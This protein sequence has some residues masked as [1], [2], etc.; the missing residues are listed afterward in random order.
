MINK[1][2]PIQFD[3]T[4][5]VAEQIPSKYEPEFD[6]ATR[7]RID[8]EGIFGLGETFE[9]GLWSTDRLDE[10]LAEV[11]ASEAPRISTFAWSRMILAVLDKR[12][13]N[14]QA[15]RGA[16][17]IGEKHYDIG[18]DLFRS[19]LD[20]SMSYTS[21]YWA[22]ADTLEQAQV[23]KLDLICRKLD[24]KPGQHI[25]DI[26]CGWG[27]FA[28]HAAKHYGARV[29]GVTVSKEQAEFARKRCEEL[30]VDIRLQDYREL[31][32]CF[33]HVVSIEMIEAV[34]RKNLPAYYRVVDRCLQDGG[35]FV[36]QV[37]SGNTLTRNSDRRL[38]QF[39][40]WLV[41]YI[42]PDGYLP[43][44]DELLPPRDT[45]L[46]IEDWH[47]YFDDYERTLLAWASQFNEH[48]EQIAD[49]YDERFRR[50]WNFYLNGCA[51][52]FRSQLID[53]SQIVYTKG[54]AL[55]RYHPVR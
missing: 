47:R 23:A 4:P 42:F 48:W 53:V 51:A 15:G 8:R 6:L 39:I 13:F 40:L 45:G 24:L 46:R 20:S 43:R 37:I 12:I 1:K 10:Y 52:I 31:H 21:G 36:L 7:R 9:E 25:L 16:F 35:L 44:T 19:M 38:D 34:G 27:N 41:R 55:T 11:F 30:P 22:T 50:R 32:E 18:N 26:G 49:Q 54:Q 14:R 29:T 3:C 28:E 5:E 2:S 17:N 33:D